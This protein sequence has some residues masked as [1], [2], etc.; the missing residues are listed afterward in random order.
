MHKS[1]QI[2]TFRTIYSFVTNF[3]PKIEAI[4]IKIKNKRQKS[5]GS[6]NSK[7]P[8]KTDPVAP[9]PVQTA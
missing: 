6:L 4:N 3:K 7:I 9:I 1:L 2:I 5:A 8:T